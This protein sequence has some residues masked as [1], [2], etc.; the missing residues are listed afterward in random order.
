MKD[1]NN[2]FTDF[3]EMIQHAWT[4]ERLTKKEKN[5]IITLLTSERIKKDTTG[6]Y[7]QRWNTLSNIYYAYL[8][9]LGYDSFNWRNEV[10]PCE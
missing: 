4:F 7:N 3:I 1:K 10:T 9:G 5:I 8:V 6:G 2:V